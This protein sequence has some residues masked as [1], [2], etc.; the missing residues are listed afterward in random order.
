MNFFGRGRQGLDV[1][2]R[3]VG[4]ARHGSE[5]AVDG[6]E[7][8]KLGRQQLQQ[9]A[10]GIAVHRRVRV[11][12]APQS[13]ELARVVQRHE[14]LRPRCLTP[15]HH[16]LVPRQAASHDRAAQAHRLPC[17]PGVRVEAER[18]AR[19]RGGVGQQL[20]LT[21]PRVVP[22][23]SHLLP[24]HELPGELLHPR[25]A[26]RQTHVRGD[27]LRQAL[28]QLQLVGVDA[29][30]EHV[31]AAAGPDRERSRQHQVPPAGQPRVRE[32]EP[33]EGQGGRHEVD[34]RLPSQGEPRV[35]PGD[36]LAQRQIEVERAVHDDRQQR[37]H[38]DEGSHIVRRQRGGARLPAQ[39]RVQEP[40]QRAARGEVSGVPQRRPQGNPS[41]HQVA[42]EHRER[43]DHGGERPAA[44]EDRVQHHAHGVRGEP[45]AREGDAETAAQR[46]NG[47]E[48]GGDEGQV[49]AGRRVA[50]RIRDEAAAEAGQ[51]GQ[52]HQDADDARRRGREP[53][54]EMHKLCRASSGTWRGVSSAT[55][56]YICG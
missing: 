54:E 51:P 37:D 45:V 47:D 28:D 55:I 7:Q 35:H 43:G 29:Q 24:G 30:P 27:R 50:G 46:G 18:G 39:L 31:Q 3:L 33:C 14:H 26:A 52:R 22:R 1:L 49:F 13:Y 2:R 23:E 20:H 21:R 32:G 41:Q 34:D 11:S 44:V 53:R 16:D 40:D 5:R 17:E 4:R 25:K 12:H 19:L 42:Y 6:D 48:G 15:R 10:V 8:R 36:G 38:D 9:Q 56:V